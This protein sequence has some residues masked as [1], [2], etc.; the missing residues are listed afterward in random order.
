[1]TEW[2]NAMPQPLPEH[3]QRILGAEAASYLASV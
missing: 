2:T 3:V 1:V